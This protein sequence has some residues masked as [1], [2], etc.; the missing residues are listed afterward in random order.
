L[1][2]IADLPTSR[3]V[4]AQPLAWEDSSAGLARI[5][6]LALADPETSFSQEEVLALLGL[7]EDEFA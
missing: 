4:F 5:S 7:A 1:K 3:Q 2:A 6:G